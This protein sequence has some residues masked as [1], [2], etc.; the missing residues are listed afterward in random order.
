M[1]IQLGA[2][3]SGSVLPSLASFAA[4]KAP[5]LLS[6]VGSFASNLFTG[7]ILPGALE[8]GKQ[9]AT[10]LINRE[11]SRD[12]V[13]AQQDAIKA[14]LRAAS[15]A[16]SP[17]VAP[18]QTA[19]FSGGPATAQAWAP[20]TLIPPSIQPPNRAALQTNPAFFPA[21]QSAQFDLSRRP[22]DFFPGTQQVGFMSEAV[23]RATRLFRDPRTG[24]AMAGVTAGAVA[25]ETGGMVAGD[26]IFP[27]QAF[28]PGVGPALA[29]RGN[30]LRIG[31]GVPLTAPTPTG[32]PGIGS[33]QREPNGVRVQWYFFNGQQME[34]IDRGQADCVRKECIYRL[35]VFTGKFVKLKSRR[36]NPMNVRAFFRA[37]RRVDAGERICRKMFSEHR[38]KKTGAVRRKSRSKKK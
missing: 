35:N 21:Q 5:S 14:A 27:N 24:K 25:L 26:F 18:G 10:G 7:T 11:L 37:G 34:A 12:A 6:Q 15:N 30:P 19:V 38:K 20:P 36:M 17:T 1:I 2:L 3:F 9:F 33:F 29:E 8:V 4:P 28:A 16:V 13:N 22:P 23:K 32:L 31:G